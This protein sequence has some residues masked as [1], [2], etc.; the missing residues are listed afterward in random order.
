MNKCEHKQAL[1]HLFE[2]MKYIA[3]IPNF[4]GLFW[5]TLCLYDDIHEH[6]SRENEWEY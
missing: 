1:V 6:R 3:Y 4:M 2:S 5:N